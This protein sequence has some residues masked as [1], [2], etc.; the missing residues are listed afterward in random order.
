MILRHLADAIRGQN[1]FTVLIEVAVVVVGIFLGLQVDDW[2]ERRKEHSL[3]RDF[4]GRLEAEVDANI[5]VYQTAIQQAESDENLYRNYFD[6]LN[7]P[8]APSP[9]E[10]QLLAG[11]CRVGVK[12]RPPFDNSV[13]D[14]LVSAGRSDIIGYVQLRRSLISYRTIQD[15]WAEGIAQLAPVNRKSFSDLEEYIYWRPV[16]PG[17]DYGHCLFDFETFKTNNKAASR[18]AH[19][20]RLQYFYLSAYKEILSRL[21]EVR[22]ALRRGYP[23]ITATANEDIEET[24]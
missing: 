7:D 10:S 18:I 16:L 21:M 4:I 14:E 1:W 20:Q 2:N 11:L 5:A 8:A 12:P 22:T 15:R 3:E 24:P 17:G 6:Y 19:A 23:Q 9:D 13:Y